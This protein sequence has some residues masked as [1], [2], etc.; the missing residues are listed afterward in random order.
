MSPL[1]YSAKEIEDLDDLFSNDI[2]FLGEEA[3][4]TNFKTKSVSASVIHVSTHSFLFKNY[5]VVIF[6]GDE[7][8]D[9]YLETGEVAGD[10]PP[11][12][13][14]LLNIV[15]TSSINCSKRNCYLRYRRR[16]F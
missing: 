6:S 5:P 10:L 11:L 14:P 2:I 8:N 3:T 13:V 7:Q 16:K 15:P 9:G 12:S 4:E 1:K